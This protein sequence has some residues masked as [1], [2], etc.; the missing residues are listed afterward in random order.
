MNTEKFYIK[1]NNQLNL[2][3]NNLIIFDK[4]YIQII[5]YVK[6]Y[7]LLRI[8]YLKELQVKIFYNVK[9]NIVFK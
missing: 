5:F 1:N 8:F 2:K 9:N 6:N 7:F 4:F 3:L